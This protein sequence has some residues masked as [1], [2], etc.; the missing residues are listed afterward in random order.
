MPPP[1]SLRSAPG[2]LPKEYIFGLTT[3]AIILHG[4][5]DRSSPL[6]LITLDKGN[7]PRHIKASSVNLLDKAPNLALVTK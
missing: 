2:I 3:L 5:P 1:G 7:M 4:Y 6:S